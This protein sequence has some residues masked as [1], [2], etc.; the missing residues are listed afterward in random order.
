MDNYSGVGVLDKAAIVLGALEAG[1]RQPGRAGRRPPG[2]PGRP[3]TGWP[4]RWRTTGCSPATLQGRFVLGPRLGE[5]ADRRR[6]GPAARP[7]PSRCSPQLRDVTGESAQLYR[8][9][10]DSGSASPRA[11]R[12]SGLR[13]TVPV[14][15]MLPMAA[16]SAAQ[17]LLAWEEPER[18]HRGLRGRKFTGHHAGRGTPPRL[19]AERRRA[20][21]GRGLGVRAGARPGRPGGRRGLRL[22]ADRAAEPPARPA[23]R[24]DRLRRGRQAQRGAAAAGGVPSSRRAASRQRGRGAAATGTPPS[25]GRD[26]SAGAPV[27]ASSAAWSRAGD[28]GPDDP[29][30]DR[31]CRRTR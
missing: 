21:A 22:R 26:A 15:A 20:R 2:C 16:G 1:P 28:R 31:G 24:A 29:V 6:R 19:G 9:Q 14:G 3:R 10:G 11:E 18:L 30:H 23:A 5:L 17:I 8:R 13:D 27:P 4:R 25:P 7:P 12:L